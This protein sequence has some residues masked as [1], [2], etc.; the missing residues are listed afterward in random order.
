M[1]TTA[2]VNAIKAHRAA[3]EAL[4]SPAQALAD[5]QFLTWRTRL[6]LQPRVAALT[7]DRAAVA[8]VSDRHH[9]KMHH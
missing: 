8:S 2:P 5:V 7:V 4:R 3:A 1:C 9:G 6:C